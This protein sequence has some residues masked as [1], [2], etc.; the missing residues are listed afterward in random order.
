MAALRERGMTVPREIS[1][2]GLDDI[3]T[4]RDTTPALTTV[5]LPLEERG[6]RAARL[7]LRPEPE[8][9]GP[10]RAAAEVL[11]RDST[12]RLTSG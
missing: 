12:R 7:V 1:V 6:E 9:A 11:L 4:P 2:A 3:A 5:R 10:L 8:P